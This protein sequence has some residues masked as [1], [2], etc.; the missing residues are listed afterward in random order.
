MSLWFMSSGSNKISHPNIVPWVSVG[1]SLT[2]DGS[3]F[4]TFL[5]IV[6]ERQPIPKGCGTCIGVPP[7]VKRACMV[8]GMY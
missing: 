2:F 1:D 5:G 6:S 8:V 3:V 4:C 7:F